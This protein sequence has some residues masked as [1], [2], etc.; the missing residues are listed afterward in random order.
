MHTGRLS[1]LLVAVAGVLVVLGG[2]ASTASSTLRPGIHAFE[3]RF[4]DA[5]CRG[6]GFCGTGTLTGFGAVTTHLVLGPA[7]PGPAKGCLGVIGTRTLT[8]TSDTKSTLRLSVRGA[9]CGSRTWGTFKVASG[10]GVFAGATGSGVI[11]GTL[12]KKTGHESLRY[13]GV[14]TLARK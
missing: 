10:S 14:L 9:A 11:I 8:P 12:T 7:F 3:A 1:R 6:G 4:Q 13:W 5:P 2:F